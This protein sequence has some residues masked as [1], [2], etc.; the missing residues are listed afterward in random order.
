MPHAIT[1]CAKCGA[2][3][4]WN[5]DFQRCPDCPR[6]GYNA[7]KTVRGNLDALRKAAETGDIKTMNSLL[8]D[9]W[10]RRNINAGPWTALHCAVFGNQI[11]AARW[12]LDRGADPDPGYRDTDY[13]T[14]IHAA[15]VRHR[16]D[17][18]TLLMEH[19]ADA[20]SK[21]DRGLRIRAVKS[22]IDLAGDNEEMRALLNQLTEKQKVWEAERKVQ[23]ERRKTK[24]CIMCGHAL[25]F[26]DKLFGRLQHGRCKTF[27]P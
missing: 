15:V 14:P 11:E 7:D 18:V 1:T 22:A 12:L 8:R 3:Y 19:G 2:Q 23:A 10:T 20:V 17:F 16:T 24:S 21:G 5:S 13:E 27:T 4:S 26:F 9:E 25:G 6:C